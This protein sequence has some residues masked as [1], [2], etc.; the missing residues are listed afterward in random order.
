MM[1]EAT[2]GDFFNSLHLLTYAGLLLLISQGSGRIAELLRGPRL[3]G[4]LLAGVLFGPYILGLF[5]ETLVNEKL[6]IITDT[7]LSI[8]AFSI[9][10]LR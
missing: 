9:G 4:Y 6:T 7:A 1:L 5:N 10:G 8:I 2:L 3:T